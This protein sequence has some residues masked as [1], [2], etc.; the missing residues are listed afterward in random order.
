VSRPLIVCRILLMHTMHMLP[1]RVFRLKDYT[2][3]ETIVKLVRQLMADKKQ[4][5]A[6]ELL[7]RFADIQIEAQTA[8]DAIIDAFIAKVTE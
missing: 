7:A 1:E 6:D 8:H 3:N 5:E 2:M 4:A